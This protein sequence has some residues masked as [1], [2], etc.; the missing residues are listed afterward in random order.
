M[1]DENTIIEA[2]AKLKAT[3]ELD[4]EDAFAARDEKTVQRCYGQ[5]RALAKLCDALSL[6]PAQVAA[7]TDLMIAARLV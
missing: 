3:A 4:Q 2:I 6:D 7:Q 1:I 5:R